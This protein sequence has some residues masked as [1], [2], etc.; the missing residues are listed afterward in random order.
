MPRFRI[1]N[2]PLLPELGIPALASFLFLAFQSN[3]ALSELSLTAFVVAVSFI[4]FLV[5][6]HRHERRLFIIGMLVGCVIEVG[7]R[8]FGYQQHWTQASFFGIPYWL[9]IAWGIGFVLITR[10]GIL[11]RGLK[12]IES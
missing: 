12:V 11:T 2:H 8:V 5:K 1:E 3:G 7:L 10:L 4:I 6:D 9:P